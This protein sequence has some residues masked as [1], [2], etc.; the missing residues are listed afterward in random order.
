MAVLIVAFARWGGTEVGRMALSAFGLPGPPVVSAFRGDA[1][2]S[3]LCPGAGA[4]GH[5]DRFVA[6]AV[7]ADQ[8]DCGELPF[9]NK[10]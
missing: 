7:R 8:I 2:G 5:H 4:Q 9:F 1:V 3:V 10:A 6:A